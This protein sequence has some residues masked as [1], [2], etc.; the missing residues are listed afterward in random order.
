MTHITITQSLAFLPFAVVIGLYVAW[1]DLSSMKIP[2]VSVYALFAVFV[3]LGPFVMP[4]ETYGLRWVQALV[5]LVIGMLLNAG[6]AMGA[7]DSKFIAAAAPF[8][9][10][11]DAVF[12]L[13]LFSGALLAAFAAHRLARISP[14]RRLVPDWLS[15]Q[16]GRRFPMGFPLAATLI[17]YLAMPLF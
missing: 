3:I 4:I 6:G 9:A 11:Q 17:Y 10:A 13:F 8:V 15:W 5:M 7:G 14:L 2:N 12:I 16:T 1:R